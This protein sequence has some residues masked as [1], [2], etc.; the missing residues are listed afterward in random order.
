MPHINWL[1]KA[2]TRIDKACDTYGKDFTLEQWISW[3]RKEF[4]RQ[5]TDQKTNIQTAYYGARCSGYDISLGQ[6]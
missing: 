2:E 3:W 5:E 4:A 1:D 6:S